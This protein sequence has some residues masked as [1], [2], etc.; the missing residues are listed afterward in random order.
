VRCNAGLDVDRGQVVAYSVMQLSG[1]PQ[2]FLAGP[3]E[4][5]LLVDPGRL[6]RPAP[7]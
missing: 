2:P 4:L 7:A 6:G 3:P 5:L 1:D